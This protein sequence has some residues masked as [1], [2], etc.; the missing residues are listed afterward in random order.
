MHARPSPARTLLH[1]VVLW[2]Q[3]ACFYKQLLTTAPCLLQ[4]SIGIDPM[5]VFSGADWALMVGAKP[6][7]PGMERA[8]LLN[9]NGEIFQVRLVHERFAKGTAV[10]CQSPEGQSSVCGCSMPHQCCL[11]RSVEQALSCQPCLCRFR[12]AAANGTTVQAFLSAV[13]PVPDSCPGCTLSCAPADPG[14][15]PERGC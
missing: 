6:R 5:E 9:Q 3:H 12:H 13:P 11:T 10:Q 2:C 8:D 14:P 15:R 1:A 7:G 4:V